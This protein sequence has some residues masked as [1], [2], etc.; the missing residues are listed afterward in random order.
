[1]PN[2]GEGEFERK[3]GP[4]HSLTNCN[5]R[6]IEVLREDGTF[7]RQIGVGELNNPWNVTINNKHVYVADTHNHR[8]AIFTLE[9]QLVRTIGSEGSGPGQ[10]NLPS[11]VAFSPDGDMYIA[12]N[13]NHRIQ[14]FTTDGVYKRE[15]WKDAYH[16][17]SSVYI[18]SGKT[19]RSSAQYRLS[20]E[21]SS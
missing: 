10:F 18:V 6:R 3:P 17:I 12:D 11:A 7:V 21:I 4:P 13:S 1:M 8:I 19:L 14:V 2:H 9:G 16:V 15:F 5:N 20:I